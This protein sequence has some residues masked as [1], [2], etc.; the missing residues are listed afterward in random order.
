MTKLSRSQRAADAV[1]VTVRMSTLLH[2]VSVKMAKREKISL[3][4][5]IRQAL[6][7]HVDTLNNWVPTKEPGWMTSKGKVTR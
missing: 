7:S 4:E 3:S 1:T 5:L 6:D 2:R